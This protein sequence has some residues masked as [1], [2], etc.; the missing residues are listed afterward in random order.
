MN[1][2]ILP[3]NNL[4]LK[5]NI[6][7]NEKKL[8]PHICNSL[9]YYLI[10]NIDFFEYNRNENENENKNETNNI[11]NPFEIIYQYFLDNLFLNFKFN[12]NSNIFFE[13]IE[14]INITNLYNYFLNNNNL[15]FCNLTNNFIS[16]NYLFD[17]INSKNNYNIINYDFDYN[18]LIKIFVNSDKWKYC[19]KFDIFII[20]FKEQDYLNNN[21]YIK[22]LILTLFIII[23][24]QNKFGT[25]IIKIDNIFYKSIID[26]IYILTILFE[27]IS[28]IKPSLTN[29]SKGIKYL[30]CKNFYINNNKN[31]FKISYLIKQLLNSNDLN[32]YNLHNL[33]YNPINYYFLNKLEEINNIFGFNQLEYYDKLNNLLKLKNKDKKIENLKMQYVE[34][35]IK[36]WNKNRLPLLSNCI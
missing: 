26:I 11:F 4:V 34:K 23:K 32:N 15:T 9:Y 18:N 31:I 16:I 1:Y 6:V 13:L 20:E 28:I 7:L 33:L 24:Y 21:S 17:I 19:K 3:K 27:Q 12:P 5:L 2:Y 36:W 25:T 29:N 30:Y 10:N 35:F 8:E 14:F 22:N